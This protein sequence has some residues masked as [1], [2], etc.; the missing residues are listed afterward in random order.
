M[1]ILFKFKNN[2]K[3][4]NYLIYVLKKNKEKKSLRYLF[5][6]YYIKIHLDNL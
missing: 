3:N 4:M 6:K 1:L 2:K 5:F